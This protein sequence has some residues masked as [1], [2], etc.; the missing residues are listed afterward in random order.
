MITGFI[1]KKGLMTSVFTED[2]KRIAV[3]K[4]V[5]LPL[6]VT[7]VKN[8]EKDGYQAVQV[9][10]GSKKKLDKATSAKLTK[11]NVDLKPQHFKEFTAAADQTIEVGNDIAIDSVFAV[12]DTVDATGITKGRGFAGVIKRHNFKKQPIKNASDRIR[13]PG[14]IGAQTPGK[15]VRGKKMPGHMGVVTKTI[16]N[17]KVVAVNKDTNEILI[18]GSVPGSFNSWV[19]IS[20]RA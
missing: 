10:Y 17:L 3:T 5:A 14:S 12:G 18:S 6:K 20:K 4:C 15:V 11:I 13:A 16:T 2:G 8:T 9:A 19:T 1:V 7:Q